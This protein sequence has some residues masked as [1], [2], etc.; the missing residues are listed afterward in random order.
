MLIKSGYYNSSFH[1]GCWM[2]NNDFD[3]RTTKKKHFLLSLL[4]HEYT[5]YQI[6]AFFKDKQI[7]VCN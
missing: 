1:V 2:W 6:L 5:S 4:F 7:N 3:F